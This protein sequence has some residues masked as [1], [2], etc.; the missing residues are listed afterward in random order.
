MKRTGDMDRECTDQIL[1]SDEMLRKVFDSISAHIAIIDDKGWILETNAAWKKF[2]LANGLSGTS[3]FRQ[4]NYLQ[5]CEVSKGRGFDEAQKV[6]SGIR[7]VIAR[8]TDEFLYDYPCHGPGEKR[9]FYMRVIRMAD[10]EPVRLIISHENI[11][12]LKRAQEA[13]SENRNM[14]E[15]KN[16]SLEEAN[17]ALKVL[18][19]QRETDRA[20]M[21][22][23]FLTN[24][25]TF[26]HPYI[27]KLKGSNLKEKD[28]TLVTIL[29]DHL[30]DIISPLM[31][32]FT[33]ANVMLTPQEMQVAVLVKDGK[34]TSE[35]ADV[36]YISEATVSF[37]RRNL[38]N[39][40]GLK[41]RQSNLR[42]FLLSMSS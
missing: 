12:D 38:R 26:V 8:R 37:H 33:N 35:I 11:T 2:A 13:L 23:K 27:E 25:R 20:E 7:K 16:Q 21:E 5:V 6:V 36:L 15:D 24:I 28:R 22:K 41:N 10:S 32:K 34:T 29:D 19:Q 42:S 9:W 1:F 3:D 30:K 40:L 17:I 14:L 4:M 31:S 39:K 18:I